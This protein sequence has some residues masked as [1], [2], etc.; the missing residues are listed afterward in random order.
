LYF[1]LFL[2]KIQEINLA[3]T[4]F[5]NLPLFN[6]ASSVGAT[7]EGVAPFALARLGTTV[8]QYLPRGLSQAVV[9][10]SPDMA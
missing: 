7:Y 3:K 5:K 8:A 9:V 1:G 4:F 2:N 10:A 6:R